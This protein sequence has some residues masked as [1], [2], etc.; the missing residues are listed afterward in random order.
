MAKEIQD[1][2]E[3]NVLLDSG[4]NGSL[5]LPQTPIHLL[6]RAHPNILKPEES[7]PKKKAKSVSPIRE[8]RRLPLASK[9][10]NRS[11]AAGPAKKR[12]PT[13]Q[14]ELLSNPKKLKKYGSV[15]GYTDLPRTKSLVLKDGDDEDEEEEGSE[16]HNKLQDA[17]KRGEDS[18]EG[19]GGL[20]KLVQDIK[21]D[22][23][24]APQKLPPL[25]Y[26][27]DG[28]TRWE[29]KDI[30][31]LK[32]VDLRVREDQDR[33]EPNEPKEL[34]ENDEGLLPLISVDSNNEGLNESEREDIPSKGHGIHP[35]PKLEAFEEDKVA[36]SYRGE[37][38][39]AQELEDLLR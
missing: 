35:F 32:T 38:L 3:N 15:L 25:E 21:D 7:T 1:N 18:S 29:D 11:G 28:H 36:A 22:V 10:H 34:S 30:E 5:A 20:A 17:I 23:E 26:E 31:K 39:S 12:Q 6:K 24:Y 13:P 37:G 19:L 4:E 33:D 14:G 27:P 2:K 8:Q 16:L 9:D